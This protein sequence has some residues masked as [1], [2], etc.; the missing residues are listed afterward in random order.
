M[1]DHYLEIAFP[2]PL[3]RQFHYRLPDS[4]QRRTTCLGMRVRA[5]FGK[6][7]TLTG[8]VVG[9]T[10]E[11]P[12][13]PTKDILGWMDADPFIDAT[14]LEMAHWL[15][16][17]YLCSLGEALAC[18]APPA[19]EAPKRVNNRT[20]DWGLATGSGLPLPVAVLG[21]ES[22][23]RPPQSS[24]L[25]LTPDQERV[26]SHLLEVVESP[27]F[28]PFLLRGVTDSGKTEVYLRVIDHAVARNRQALFLLPEIALTP[29]FMER[30]QE[31]YGRG[32]V[33][34]WHSG[35]PA[36]ERYRVWTAVRSGQ[37][38][39]LL[40]ARSAVFA[41]F[42]ALGVLIMDEEH[43]PSYKQEDR[44]R[45][46]TREVAL[47]RAEQ[48]QAVLVM[49]SATPSLESYW[50]AL[51]G[52]Y[53][54]LEL[55]SR[56]EQR[57]LPAV[58]LID[59]RPPGTVEPEGVAPTRRKRAAT[60]SVFSESLK[61][62]IEQRLARREQIML[63]VNRRG[64]TPFLR[65]GTCGWV[66]RCPRCSTTLAMHLKEEP[67]R[68]SKL[69]SRSG[70]EATL[71]P[72]PADGILQCHACLH[73]EP[74]PI[75][76]PACRGMRLRDYGIGTQR[77]EEELKKLFPFVKLARLDRDSA[78]KRHVFEKIY[79]DFASGRVEVLVGTQ[80]IAKGFD[81]PNVTLVGV[82]D[83]DVSLHLPDFRSCERTFQLIAQVAGRTGR[84]TRPGIVLVQTH[85]PEHY[86]LQSAQAHDY[87]T[88]YD[89]EIGYREA[90]R[91]PPFSQL[92]HVLIRGTHLTD[93][94]TAAELLD[95]KL[96]AE[97]NG[98]EILGP[99]PA[100]YARIR[101]QFRFQILLKGN[102][103]TLRPA[104]NLLRRYRASK[105]FVSVDV[106]P[107]DLL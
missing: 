104:L 23:L 65:C 48:T 17:R 79:R 21:P 9:E 63:F 16:K 106:D 72:V 30:L 102:D 32:A 57:R 10:N 42:P 94:Q 39:V 47:K 81:F 98:V 101:G 73:A 59:R 69:V 7:K 95:A 8:Y 70:R 54:L 20:Q 68:V 56:V 19:L 50:N 87:L 55:H 86:A 18:I 97:T 82:V 100:P 88:F 61:L 90:L 34:L 99:S 22:S 2:I 84:G 46:H 78:S 43:E 52:R 53:T 31:R 44:P 11:T 62:A 33:G 89:R 77:V 37:I 27:R 80:M 85:H 3:D 92:V 36:G 51:Q 76:C 26:L 83:A 67:A 38:K 45:Y 12:S 14:L 66:A 25:S 28:E 6:N 24:V 29:P 5:P 41:P 105:A 107:A 91:Y 71:R 35:I 93:V 75:Q 15:A 40:G 103:E 13:F 4:L 96:R 1:T 60:F 74:V 64:F 58:T 49:G